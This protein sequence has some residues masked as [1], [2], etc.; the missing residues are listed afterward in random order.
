MQSGEPQRD[1]SLGSQRVWVEE[2]IAGVGGRTGQDAGPSPLKQG[3]L[4]LLQEQQKAMDRPEQRHE[5]RQ[6]D[7]PFE[8]MKDGTGEATN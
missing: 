2:S 3:P 5:M 4:D 7:F 8:R 6:S 1:I